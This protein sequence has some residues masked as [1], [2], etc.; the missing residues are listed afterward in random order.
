MTAAVTIRDLL[1]RGADDAIAITA[2]SAVP[3]T[4]GG[5]REQVDATIARL[6]AVGVG[7]SDRV[8][9]VLPNGPEMAAAFLGI[10]A[11]ATSAPLNPQYRAEEFEF[12]LT[13]LAA[14][15]LVVEAGHRS[16]ATDVAAR[17]GVPVIGLQPT[18]GKGA[19]RFELDAGAAPKRAPTAGG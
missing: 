2:P 1:A 3:L 6:N 5:L 17:L 18:P 4:Y 7:R 19:G 14:K 10:A 8:A 11:G 13:D 15:A 16:A 12:Y 9:I